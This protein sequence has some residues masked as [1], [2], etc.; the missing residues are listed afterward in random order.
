M[1]E[2]QDQ[3]NPE[4]ELAV[5]GLEEIG[6]DAGDEYEQDRHG[7]QFETVAGLVGV[8]HAEENEQSRNNQRHG[9]AEVAGARPREERDQRAENKDGQGG[10]G[11]DQNREQAGVSGTHEQR[12]WSEVDEMRGVDAGHEGAEAE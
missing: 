8:H 5:A 1:Q 9:V 6:N 10:A 4:Y 11:T 3:H 12:L 7:H 2:K